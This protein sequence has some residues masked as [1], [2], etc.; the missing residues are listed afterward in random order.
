MSFFV[1]SVF[2]GLFDTALTETIFKETFGSLAENE[3][4][5][6]REMSKAP[7]AFCLSRFKFGCKFYW[8]RSKRVV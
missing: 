8:P 1:V 4:T 5:A 6:V 2:V 7:R 3:S